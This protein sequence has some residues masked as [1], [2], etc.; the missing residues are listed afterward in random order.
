M[1]RR[2]LSEEQVGPVQRQVA[3]NLVG[4]DL[5]VALYAV[6]PAGV[7]QHRGA[8]DVGLQEDARVLDAAI[9]MTLR[10]EV[11]DDVGVLL[12]EQPVHALPVADVQL[13]E[14]KVRV[15]HHRGEGEQ[16]SRVCQL[17]H[18][19]DPVIRIIFQHVENEV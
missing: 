1:D 18:T 9:H 11:Y 8:D 4:G 7:H 17:V 3:V 13:H 2:L 10:R 12:L 5:V 15:V 14:P 19:D 6:F 16:I